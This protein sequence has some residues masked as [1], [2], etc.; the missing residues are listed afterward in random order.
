MLVFTS[1]AENFGPQRRVAAFPCGVNLPFATWNNIV[2]I[3][4]TTSRIQPDTCPC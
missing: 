2:L 1:Q 3:T 4:C